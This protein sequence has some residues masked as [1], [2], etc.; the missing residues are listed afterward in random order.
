MEMKKILFI[1]ISSDNQTSN[2]MLFSILDQFAIRNTTLN[3]VSDN[4]N[5]MENLFTPKYMFRLFCA[6][7]LNNTF[8]KKF[9]R[10]S[11]KIIFEKSANIQSLK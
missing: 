11:E 8:L 10:P 3:A 1:S 9:L 6:Y 7:H 4:C 5:V 2:N